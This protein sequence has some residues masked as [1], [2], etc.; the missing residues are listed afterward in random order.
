MLYVVAAEMV[1]PHLLH[2]AGHLVPVHHVAVA[3]QHSTLDLDTLFDVFGVFQ[4]FLSVFF[5][6]F[7]PLLQLFKPFFFLINEEGLLGVQ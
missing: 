5:E 2:Q 4:L 6:G 1:I 7:V 3:V